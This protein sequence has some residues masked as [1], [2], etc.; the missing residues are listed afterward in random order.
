MADETIRTFV[1][2]ELPHEVRRELADLIMLLKAR[3]TSPDIKWVSPGSIHITLKFLGNVSVS[4][5][6]AIRDCLLPVCAAS[7]PVRLRTA[8][9]GAFP[10]S[11]SPR[12]LW[13]GLEGD[14]AVLGEMSRSIDRALAPIGFAAE[15]RAF[16][17]HLTL[18]RVRPGT[19]AETSAAI[20]HAIDTIPAGGCSAFDANAAAIMRSRLTP[21]GAVYSRLASLAF[22]STVDKDL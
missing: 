9:L 7:R 13:A 17:P 4:Q 2:I 6:N 15:T 10:A 11:R 14:T 21:A 20:S 12:V 3:V 22:H 19:S 16:T 8:G 1:A 18:A 5:I